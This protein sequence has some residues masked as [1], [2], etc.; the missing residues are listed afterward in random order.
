[1]QSSNFTK[2]KE[3]IAY[4]SKY[5][6]GSTIDLGAGSAKYRSIIE[7]RSSKYLTFDVSSGDRIDVVGDIQKLPFKENNFDTIICT[8]VLEHVKKP[9][10]AV[11]EMYRVIKPNGYS[12]VTVPFMLPYHAHPNDYFRY[13]REGLVSIFEDAGFKIIN[14][15]YYGSI[16]MVIS[17]MIHFNLFNPYKKHKLNLPQIMLVIENIAGRLDKIIKSENTNA[18]VYIIAQK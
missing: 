14:C 18:N 5:I 9:W 4:A 6:K 15:Q 13:T 16:F 8:Q 1:M 2:T 3:F 12:L 17:E 7:G 11:K 10:L